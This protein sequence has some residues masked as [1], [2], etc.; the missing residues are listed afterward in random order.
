MSTAADHGRLPSGLEQYKQRE[1][2]RDFRTTGLLNGVQKLAD[3]M[4]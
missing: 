4:V 1:P 3:A 2:K